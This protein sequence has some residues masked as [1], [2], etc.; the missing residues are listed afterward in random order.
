M[1]KHAPCAW[2]TKIY[3]CLNKYSFEKKTKDGI[4]YIFREGEK[5]A[6]LMLYV[7]DVHLIGNHIK[8]IQWIIIGKKKFQ[9]HRYEV[10][11]SFFGI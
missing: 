6:L 5:V 4:L 1:L 7:H 2:Y 9:N 11:E 10:I 8:K 3:E